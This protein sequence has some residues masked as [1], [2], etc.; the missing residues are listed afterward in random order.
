MS[1]KFKK[2]AVKGGGKSLVNVL[3][4]SVSGGIAF[5]LSSMKDVST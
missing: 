4:L 3:R 5:K 2:K 1:E